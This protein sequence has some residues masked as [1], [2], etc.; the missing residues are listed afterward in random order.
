MS[1]S[2]TQPDFLG[3]GLSALCRN[4]CFREKMF[5]VAYCTF[6]KPC[7]IQQKAWT[8][9]RETSTVHRPRDDPRVGVGVSGAVRGTVGYREHY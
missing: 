4:Q 6:V 9:T 8:R 5:V 3:S 2:R 1:T 7:M